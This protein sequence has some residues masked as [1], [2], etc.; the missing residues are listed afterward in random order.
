MR[1]LAELVLSIAPIE[2]V[3]FWYRGKYGVYDAPLAAQRN[4]GRALG[5]DPHPGA[6]SSQAVFVAYTL[7]DSDPSEMTPQGRK[8]RDDARVFLGIACE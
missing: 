7:A 5:F 2:F 8:R 4:I 3:A 6:Y 1:R